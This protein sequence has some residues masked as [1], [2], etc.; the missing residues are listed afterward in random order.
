MAKEITLVDRSVPVYSCSH[1][2]AMEI[3]GKPTRPRES[4]IEVPENL[5][6][7]E[8]EFTRE[9]GTVIDLLPCENTGEFFERE[10]DEVRSSCDDKIWWVWREINLVLERT[11]LRR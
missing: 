6:I 9:T 10:R 7:K 2:L 3:S 11:W 4:S 5:P 8:V 1:I